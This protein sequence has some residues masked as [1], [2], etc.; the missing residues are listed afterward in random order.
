MGM[1]TRNEAVL[2]GNAKIL[3]ALIGNEP[4]F[5][6]AKSWVDGREERRAHFCF[7]TIEPVAVSLCHE[8]CGDCRAYVRAAG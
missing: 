3:V 2:L 8:L 5:V 1:E 4:V 6:K 7:F